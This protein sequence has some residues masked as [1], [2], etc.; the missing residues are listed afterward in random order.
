MEIN[1]WFNNKLMVCQLDA[2]A[3]FYRKNNKIDSV[4]LDQKKS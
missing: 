3:S 1:H 2:V 4:F